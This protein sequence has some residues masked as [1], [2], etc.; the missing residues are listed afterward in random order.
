MCK[1]LFA[2]Q[3]LTALKSSCVKENMLASPVNDPVDTTMART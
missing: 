1:F 3:L 2:I